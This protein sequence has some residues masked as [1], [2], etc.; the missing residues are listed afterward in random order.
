MHARTKP[1]TEPYVWATWITKLLAGES[2]CLWSAWFRAHFHSFAK[3]ERADFDLDKWIVDHAALVRRTAAEFTDKG[4]AVSTERQNQFSLAGKLGTLA[5]R[6]DMVA[7]QGD[8]GW[9]VDGKTGLP[10]AA[11][12]VQVMLYMWALKRANPAL[13]GVRLRGRIEY[14]TRFGIVEA[15][16]VDAGFAARVG[17]VMRAV[18][19]PDE[20]GKAPSFGECRCC[21]LTPD[22]CAER[23]DEEAVLAAVTDEF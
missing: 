4:Y 12:R 1:R 5:G 8:E 9:V 10:R 7:V 13:A 2:S 23:V 3:T 15:D 19:G 6:P 18:C 11:D 20:P 14:P 17:E 16:E 21:P 22:D